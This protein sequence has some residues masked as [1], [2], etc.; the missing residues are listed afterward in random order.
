MNYLLLYFFAII[1]SFSIIGHGY[2]LSKIINKDLLNFNI[3]YQGLLGIF[4]LT[5]ISYT[6]IF[7]VKHGYFHNLIIHF[8]GLFSLQ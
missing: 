8:I 6:T 1:L 3:G 4:F 7:F 5:T 2:L